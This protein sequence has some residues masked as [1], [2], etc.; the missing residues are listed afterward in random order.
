MYN[1]EN[2]EDK[3]KC[4]FQFMVLRY[5]WCPPQAA[6]IVRLRRSRRTNWE[7]YV[8]NYW[9]LRRRCIR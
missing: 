3:K 2:F 7:N 9:T 8:V 4:F 1:K 6:F 5:P